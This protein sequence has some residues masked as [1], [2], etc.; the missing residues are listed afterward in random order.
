MKIKYIIDFNPFTN[1]FI[2]TDARDGD[3]SDI[4]QEVVIT[5][6]KGVSFIET[7]FSSA[8]VTKIAPAIEFTKSQEL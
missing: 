3:T 7:F 5:L 4:N 1:N 6:Y 8:A 2:L